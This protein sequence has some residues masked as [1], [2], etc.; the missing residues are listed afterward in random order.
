MRNSSF[1]VLRGRPAFQH[2]LSCH[3]QIDLSPGYKLMRLREQPATFANAP[4]A[5]VKSM[6]TV[7]PIYMRLA[8]EGGRL[9][10]AALAGGVSCG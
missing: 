1:E 4:H 5:A 6:E 7:A 8:R 2:S 9:S 3:Q 10:K